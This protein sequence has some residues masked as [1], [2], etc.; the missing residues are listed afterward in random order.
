M[1]H[2]LGLKLVLGRNFTPEEDRPNGEKVALLGYDLWHRL[3]SGDR[4][5]LGRILVLD[6]EPYKVVGV[7]PPKPYFPIA[8]KSGYH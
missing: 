2:V 1:L 8:P 3:F 6:D 4:E 7:L 5:V